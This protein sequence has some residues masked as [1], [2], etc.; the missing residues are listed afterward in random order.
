MPLNLIS[1]SKIITI[2]AVGLFLTACKT[3]ERFLPKLTSRVVDNAHLLSKS[4]RNAIELR[5]K[6]FD[7]KSKYEIV[8]LTMEEIDDIEDFSNRAFNAWKIG[9]GGIDSGLLIVISKNNRKIRFEIGRG[10]EAKI[11][12][13]IA[14]RII[15]D[16]MRQYL[17]KNDYYNALLAGIK[18][19]EERITNE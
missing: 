13:M 19:I 7:Q 2:I 1:L 11:P 18:A 17:S 12:D 4:E 9:K 15:Q 5:L 10:T 6:E 16:N 3:D 14:N 8:I